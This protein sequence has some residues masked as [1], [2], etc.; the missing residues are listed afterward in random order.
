MNNFTLKLESLSCQGNFILVWR[1]RISS[2]LHKNRHI[3]STN[4]WNLYRGIKCLSKTDQISSNRTF[5]SLETQKGP[6]VHTHC[7]QTQNTTP[8]LSFCRLAFFVQHALQLS[9]WQSSYQDCQVLQNTFPHKKQKNS[10][11]TTMRTRFMHDSEPVACD[12]P[13][14]LRWLDPV[15]A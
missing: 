14:I 13:Q 11:L 5:T 6:K 1:Q 2:V 9:D 7:I 3:S 15:R 8:T 10:C 4:G 12:K